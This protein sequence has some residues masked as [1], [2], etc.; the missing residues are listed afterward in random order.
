MFYPGNRGAMYTAAIVLYALTAGTAGF[1]SAHL[2][3]RRRDTPLALGRPLSCAAAPVPQGST[4]PALD[5]PPLRLPHRPA[6]PCCAFVQL[7]NRF[8]REP[9]RLSLRYRRFRFRIDTR[10]PHQSTRTGSFVACGARAQAE[11]LGKRAL[12]VE[13]GARAPRLGPFAFKLLR[14]SLA[15]RR[16]RVARACAFAIAQSRMRARNRAGARICVR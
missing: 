10:R 15:A 11:R 3:C 1:V 2:Y 5:S 12:G 7:A 16:W 13:P 14:R 4:L 9:P 6:T 8:G